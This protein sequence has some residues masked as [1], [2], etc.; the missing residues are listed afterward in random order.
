MQELIPHGEIYTNYAIGAGTTFTPANS[1]VWYHLVTPGSLGNSTGA[2]GTP[3]TTSYNSTVSQY[4]DMPT[5]GVIQYIGTDDVCF[6]TAWTI[7]ISVNSAGTRTHYFCIAKS[8]GGVT[9]LVPGSQVRMSTTNSG[10]FSSTAIHSAMDLATNDRL[11]MAYLQVGG[12]NT[13]TIGSM[14]VFIMGMPC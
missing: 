9:T 2:L 11:S 6:H 5:G 10:F 14:N 4:V 8:S 3:I 7:S 12:T 13:L 1:S